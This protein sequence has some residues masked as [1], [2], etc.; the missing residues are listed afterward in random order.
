MKIIIMNGEKDIWDE[1]KIGKAYK[2][3]GAKDVYT[4]K[5]GVLKKEDVVEIF[6]E[7]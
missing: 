3:L 5:D 6:I 7:R 2:V 4:I 1:K